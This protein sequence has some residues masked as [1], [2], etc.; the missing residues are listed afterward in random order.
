M[1]DRGT[2]TLLRKTMAQ[3]FLPA[4]AV[5]KMHAH[6]E[7]TASTPKLRQFMEYVRSTWITNNTWLL[8]S[9]NVFMKAIRTNDDIEGWHL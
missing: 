5:P 1:N 2:Y 4:T 6:L 9:W 7:T 3:P 8:P